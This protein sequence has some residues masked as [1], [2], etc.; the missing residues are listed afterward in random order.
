MPNNYEFSA[1]E[2][3]KMMIRWCEEAAQTARNN[4]RRTGKLEFKF[5]SEAVTEADGMIEKQL[6]MRISEAF[7]QDLI[8]GEELGGPQPAEVPAGARLWQIDPIDG[9]LNYALGLP[10]Y[11]TSLALMEGQKVLAACIHQPPTGDTF[12]ALSGH[13]AR[14]NGEAMRVGTSRDLKDS[15][16]SLQLKKQGLV[17]E[18]A[19]LLH[20]LSSAPLKLRRVGAVAL[21]MAWVAAGFCDLLVASFKGK[22]H[23][24]DIAAGLL[25][26]EEAGGEALD[27]QGRPY[28]MGSPEMMVGSPR[29]AHQMVDLFATHS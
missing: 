24:W 14:L 28:R 18:N 13:G 29:V 12:S 17:M 27:F 5:A 15:I 6:R 19:Q 7:P 25:L 23:P 22:I 16:V 26:V 20:D 9:T 11:C 1:P 21:E 8:M 10:N 4:H 2:L 3:E